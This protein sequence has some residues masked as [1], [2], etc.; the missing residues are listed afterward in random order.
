MGHSQHLHGTWRLLASLACVTL[1]CSL[2]GRPGLA[3][4]AM[5]ASAEA[6]TPTPTA[7]GLSVTPSPP[8]S[9]IDALQAEV[10]AGE[11][12]YEESLIAG[13]RLLAGELDLEVALSQTPVE[14]EG[15][16]IVHDAQLYLL[17]GSDAATQAELD[18]LLRILIPR[19]E[20][21]LEF[22]IPATS[23]SGRGRGVARPSGAEE[24]CAALWANGFPPGSD[25][26]C[27]LYK[28]A[29]V[30]SSK[31]HV[32]YPITTLPKGFTT[33][34][35][36]A[37]FQA[38]VDALK[39]YAGLAVPGR[40]TV[41]KNIQVVFS[42]L[43]G[44]TGGM[45]VTPT[46]PGHDP[47]QIILFPLA[48][49]DNEIRKAKVSGGPGGPPA[50]HAAFQQNVAHEVFHCFQIWNFPAL[51]FEATW[52]VQD[53]WAE[54]TAEYF[55]NVVYP[56]VDNEWRFMETWLSDSGSVPLFEESYEN[57]AF[58]Q[59]VGNQQGN[60]GVLSLIDHLTPAAQGDEDAQAVRLAS[61][62]G[63]QAL[64]DGYARDF[65]D[66][67]IAD[68]SKKI[69]P[70]A[71][72]LV[73]PPYQIGISQAGTISLDAAPFTLVR[74]VLTFAPGHEY[75]LAA[76]V[77][78]GGGVHTSRPVEVAGAWGD[79]PASVKPACGPTEYYLVMTTTLAASGPY[80]IALKV[81]QGDSIGCDTCLV[82]TWDL[83]IPS[84]AEY[85]EAPFQ[86]M[87]GF[88][89]FDAAGGLW[90][91]RFRADGTMRAEFDFFYTYSLH[92]DGGE[93]GADI[94]TNGKIDI[95]GTGEG[96]YISDGLSNLAFGLVQDNV[97]LK[98]EIYLNG[99]KLD[100]SVFGSLSA[101]YGFAKGDTTIYSCDAEAGQLLINVGPQA[102]LPPIQY[103]RVSTDPNKP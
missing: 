52:D 62:P 76:T 6:T 43:P 74:Y 91:Y 18:R 73:L 22:S 66:G 16:A 75:K 57:F 47:C 58:F 87:P 92:Q 80:K 41:L 69:F 17:R 42:L 55:S 93:F 89:Q 5:P 9:L 98:D 39:K 10:E 79:L 35:A 44:K 29:T 77:Q 45:A 27:F 49:E 103:D 67:K 100:A 72:P 33:A 48:I 60:N 15:T 4:A 37:A 30:G 23:S 71:P 26:K 38:V 102:N 20:T 95:D 56:T 81:A 54:S 28:E 70:S 50:S 19:P 36:D 12:S 53:W 97:S 83:N 1:A 84:F 59:Y 32:F 8:T 13:L 31:V 101:G 11:M 68:A 82:G 61:F 21:L 85:S 2:T 63:I 65:M 7:T 94:V 46:E 40:P 3:P 51:S 14:L 90:R 64:F 88:Y 78:A 24:D 86:E 96:T 25:A 99:E 34:Y